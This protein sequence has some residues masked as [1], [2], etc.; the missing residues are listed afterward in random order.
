[1]S[2]YLITQATGQQSQWII[3]HLLEADVK[4]H[5]VV[6]NIEKIPGILSDP[7]IALFQGESKNYDDV[8]KA[9]QGCKAAFLNTIPLPGLETLQAK[10]IVEA[11]EK[12]GVKTIVAATTFC[13]NRKDIWDDDE[14]KKVSLLQPYYASKFEVENIVRAGNFEGYTILRPAYLHYDFFI[15][16][17]YNNF[18]RLPTDGEIDDL[19][20]GD[21]KFPY[22]DAQDI[23]KYAAMA[24][25]YPSK[26]GGQEIDLANNLLDF[27]QVRDILVRVSGR[28]VGVFKRTPEEVKE[29]GI[30]VHGQVFQLL[31]NIKSLKFVETQAKQVQEKFGIPFTS[32]EEALKRDRA[33]LLECIPHRE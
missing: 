21:A 7:R 23:G 17:A 26:F 28:H 18:P 19:L 24:L 12:A 33:R 16:N 9:A 10:T 32:L 11:C 29:L 31:A 8:F 15:P 13:T 1:M 25:Q 27:E 30:N 4:I 22:T 5:A 20:I 3:K 14:A 6:R 2:A